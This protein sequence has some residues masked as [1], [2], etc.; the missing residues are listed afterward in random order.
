MESITDSL[1]EEVGLDFDPVYT[2]IQGDYALWRAN[3]V[4]DTPLKDKETN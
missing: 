2:D 3:V 4:N 1:R